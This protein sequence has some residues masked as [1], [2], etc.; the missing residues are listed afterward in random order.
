MEEVLRKYPTGNPD[1]G[2]PNVSALTLKNVTISQVSD[3]AIKL[4]F[5]F[6]QLVVEGLQNGQILNTTGW[7]KDPKIF[8]AIFFFPKLLIN[9]DYETDGRIL[10]L[11]MNG[12]GKGYFDLTNGIFNVRVKVALEKRHNGKNYVKITKLKLNLLPEK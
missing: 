10:V 8:E 2:M 7:T 6:L 4:N 9:G 5:K 3:S 1:I 12:K 11:A